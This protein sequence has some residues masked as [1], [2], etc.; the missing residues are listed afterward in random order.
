MCRGQA[1]EGEW[2]DYSG[3]N[4]LSSDR[5]HPEQVRG[6]V[7]RRE[8]IFKKN[9]AWPQSPLANRV[10]G[11]RKRRFLSK[12]KNVCSKVKIEKKSGCCMSV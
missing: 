3:E 4:I 6:L 11:H 8:D 1:G 2:G 9:A 12:N 10:L 5:S 7:H